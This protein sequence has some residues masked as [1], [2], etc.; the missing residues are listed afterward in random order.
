MKGNVSDY[1]F[2]PD[3]SVDGVWNG[4]WSIM[5]SYSKYRAKNGGLGTDLLPLPNNRMDLKKNA[6]GNYTGNVVSNLSEYDLKTKYQCPLSAPK[7]TF[8]V[9]AVLAKNALPGGTLIYNSR[10]AMLQDP[11]AILYV[12]SGDLNASGKLKAGVPIEPLILRARAGDCIVVNLKNNLPAT[13]LP[14]LA[15]NNMLPPIID[16]FTLNSTAPLTARDTFNAND[17]HPSNRVGLRPQLVAYDTTRGAGNTLGWNGDNTVAPG[18]SKT[19]Y[20]YAGDLTY[21]VATGKMTAT[22]VEFGATNLISSDPIKH[23]N[24]GAVGALIIEPQGSTWKE[25]AA[26]RA[27]ANVYGDSNKNGKYDAGEPLLFRDFTLIFQDDINMRF[28]DGSAVPFVAGEDDAEDSGM[29]G[30]NY[31][32]EPLWYRL[33]IDP[34]APE[35]V[36][37]GY[38]FTYALA[39]SLVGGDPQTPVFTAKAWQAIRLRILQPNG[40]PRNHVFALHGHVWQRNPY[41]STCTW[42]PCLGSTII[43]NNSL[44]EWRGSQEG[45]GPSDH[46]DIVPMYGAGGMFGVPGDY[47]YRDMTPMSFYSGI[48][49]LLRVVP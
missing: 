12:R 15:G 46:W 4:V 42:T 32:S 28:G 36:V 45:H 10:G 11:T 17:V 43:G 34:S 9:T 41:T 14:D 44:S 33:G 25:D 47:L 48:W 16:R 23:S 24:K 49:G 7:V 35:G 1:L 3:N 20:W 29:K 39:N 21:N 38:D 2:S 18:A 19:Y 6:K 22:P 27:S 30:L 31:R 37:A 40:H 8:N 5:R 26:S 13:A